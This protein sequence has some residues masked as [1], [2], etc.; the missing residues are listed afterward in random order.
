[1]W[2][3]VYVKQCLKEHKP[4]KKARKFWM[5]LN[6]LPNLQSFV[7]IICY[8]SCVVVVVLFCSGFIVSFALSS[9]LSSSYF[10]HTKCSTK[11]PSTLFLHLLLSGNKAF[12]FLPQLCYWCIKNIQ[13]LQACSHSGLPLPWCLSSEFTGT[14]RDTVAS[15]HV[16]LKCSDH[17]NRSSLFVYWR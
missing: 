11:L 10:H 14:W 2:K 7:I 13:L 16:V 17:L 1:M 15:L 4:P 5:W 8:S 6:L 9:I 3:S 12:F